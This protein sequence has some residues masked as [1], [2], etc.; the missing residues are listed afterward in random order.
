MIEGLRSNELRMEL[1][2]YDVRKLKLAAFTIGGLVAGLGGG[3]FAAWGTFVNPSVFSLAQAATVV[4]WVM[5]GGRGSLLGAF[6]G[7]F[8]VQS[9]ADAA[10]LVVTEQTPLLVG[11]LLVGVVMLMPDGIVPTLARWMKVG[12]HRSRQSPSEADDEW[13]RPLEHG[14]GQATYPLRISPSTSEASTSFE[15]SPPLSEII[16]YMRSSGP[17]VPARAR[18][19]IF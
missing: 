15:A 8:I 11:L 6:I 2:G 16:R 9:A 5:V 18:S 3:L 1:L 19:S 4:V 12:G 7:V 17:T 13:E 14:G 10:D